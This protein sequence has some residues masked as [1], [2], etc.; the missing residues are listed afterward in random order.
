MRKIAIIPAR[1][2]SK[3]LLNKNILN[4]CGKPLIAWTIEAAINSNCFERI[5]V[6]TDSKEY[7]EISEKYGAEVIYR[8]E[9]TSSDTA[10]T[11]DAIKEIFSRIDTHK[12]D[13]FALLQPTSPL[14][15]EEHILE[16]IELFETNFETKS[17][18]VSVTE[19]H[20][21]SALIKPI[22]NSLSLEKFDLDYSNYARQKIKEYEPN[23]AI[24]ISKIDYYLENKHFFGKNGIAYIM[25]RESSVDIDDNIDFE[26]AIAIQNKRIKKNLHFNSITDRIN[27]KSSH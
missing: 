7:G 18:L 25:D 4:L 20:T 11:Y 23:G 27:E 3:G 21:S 19:A 14:R 24:F 26:L 9:E 2:G 12:F 22:D 15:T 1:S 10:S 8:S 16:S 17:T 5:I 13:Y 6:S